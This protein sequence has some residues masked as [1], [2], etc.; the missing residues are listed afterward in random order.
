LEVE[1]S[2]SVNLRPDADAETDYVGFDRPRVVKVL[3]R[4]AADMD[5][6]AQHGF[7]AKVSTKFVLVTGAA[8]LNRYRRRSNSQTVS[9][10]RHYG[11]NVAC[12]RDNVAGCP[13]N[14]TA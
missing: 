5:D 1:E 4:I 2:I 3:Q 12:H 7:E 11:H 6:I 8:S 9:R 14:W 13:E 10:E